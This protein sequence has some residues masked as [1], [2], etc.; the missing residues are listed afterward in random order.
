VGLRTIT[1]RRG[2]GSSLVLLALF[3]GAS[4]TGFGPPGLLDSSSG[5]RPVYA[6]QVPQA[7]R[8]PPP[9][10]AAR[11]A[12]VIDEATGKTLFGRDEHQRLPMASTT[13]IMTALVAV[14]RGQLDQMVTVDVDAADMPDSSVMGLRPG[15][16][17]TLRDLLYGMLLPSG[18][19]AAVAIA[20]AV[21]GS[22]PAFVALMN[23]RAAELGLADTHFANPHGLDA[24]DHYTTAV[25]LAQIARVALRNPTIA[26][27]VATKEKT[28]R[29]RD[30]YNLKNTNRLLTRSDVEGVKTGTTDL[31]GSCLVAAF[32]RNGH[33]VIS[34]VLNTPDYAPD[35]LALA[36]YSYSTYAWVRPVLPIG[37]FDLDPATGQARIAL[38]AEPLVLPR[39]EAPLL[40][41]IVDGQTARLAV[42][43]E[44][45]GIAPLAR[46][47]Q[48]AR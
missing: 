26:Q 3:L 24:P 4:A 8:S 39:W 33:P 1:A 30:T 46:I 44:T 23:R 21:G 36:D 35:S 7:R 41:T 28:I 27:I 45:V 42:G 25:D 6:Y 16:R 19:D 22:E 17:L 15:E 48:E 43:G 20:R 14:E 9:T 47:D 18:N 2:R 37:P 12:V 10:V 31:A 40:R 5:D 11:S 34:V 13:K 32:R 29:G 38:A